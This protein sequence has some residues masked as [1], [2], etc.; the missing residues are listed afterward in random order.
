MKDDTTAGYGNQY[1]AITARG[2]NNSENY[3]TAYAGAPVSVKLQTGI[4]G[5]ILKGVFVTNSTYAVLS[6]ENGDAYAKKFGGSDGT[7]P[8]FSS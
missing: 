6:M 2:V 4:A 3:A 1:S 5:S 8:D 7:D